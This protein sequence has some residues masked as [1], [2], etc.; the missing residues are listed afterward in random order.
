MKTNIWAWEG[1]RA[2]AQRTPALFIGISLIASLLFCVFFPQAGKY[3][4]YAKIS[5]A[6]FSAALQE[7]EPFLELLQDCAESYYLPAPEEKKELPLSL[8]PDSLLDYV[9]FREAIV[10]FSSDKSVV[11]T[12]PEYLKSV[13]TQNKKMHLLVRKTGG[14]PFTIARMEKASASYAALDGASLL[15]DHNAGVRFFMDSPG[16]LLLQVLVPLGLGMCQVGM[17]RSWISLTRCMPDGRKRLM[18]IKLSHLAIQVFIFSL[19]SQAVYFLWAHFRFGCG[20]L[21]RA[22][23]SVYPNC[24]LRAS[25]GGVM[26][27]TAV[28]RCLACCLMAFLGLLASLLIVQNP[29]SFLLSLSFPASGWLLHRFIPAYTVFDPIKKVNLYSLFQPAS[30]YCSSDFI[31][32]LNRPVF[33]TAAA[34]AVCGIGIAA[35]AAGCICLYP[36]LQSRPRPRRAGKRKN[37]NE[38][39]VQLWRHEMWAFGI[40]RRGLAALAFLLAVLCGAEFFIKPSL[41]PKDKY[42]QFYVQ[43]ARKKPDP[44]AYL[45]EALEKADAAEMF[46]PNEWRAIGDALKKY[47]AFSEKKLPAEQFIVDTG[48]EYLFS[49]AGGLLFRAGLTILMIAVSAVLFQEKSLNT[50]LCSL[51]ENTAL[52]KKVIARFCVSFALLLTLLIQGTFYRFSAAVYT[53]PSLDAPLRA[54]SC[55][56]SIPFIGIGGYIAALGAAKWA[57]TALLL[58][59]CIVRFPALRRRRL[60]SLA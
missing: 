40:G 27:I 57:L 14:D 13:Q 23:Q 42:Y 52:R 60:K 2:L 28:T 29:F 17:E 30:L 21:A 38:H 22:A 15:F 26:G 11:D 37:P 12:Y 7:R 46:N 45:E 32:L 16:L 1:R 31:R 8:L 25:I 5:G 39:T 59:A 36:P 34:F 10:L 3:S 47:Q 9:H 54:L 49:D 48:Y 58:Y 18:L 50:L 24:L 20:T 56:P 41:T 51:P 44:H 19:F 6:Y 4:D 55:A 43:E 35:A 53:L 33:P